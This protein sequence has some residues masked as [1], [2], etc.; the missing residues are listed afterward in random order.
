LAEW[1]SLKTMSDAFDALAK[2]SLEEAIAVADQ[3]FA[4][5]RA[6]AKRSEEDSRFQ[7]KAVAARWCEEHD[8]L[9]ALQCPL[10]TST[11]GADNPLWADL[12]D[13]RA[14]GEAAA[15]TFEDNV[16]RINATLKQ[17]IPI[18]LRAHHADVLALE[19]GKSLAN[20]VRFAFVDKPQ[21]SQALSKFC[22]LVDTALQKAPGT[23]LA[24]VATPE[25]S[26]ERNIAVA[27]R[28]LAL[29]GWFKTNSDSWQKWWN[30]LAEGA[31]PETH[32]TWNT[33]L[34]LATNTLE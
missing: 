17:A 26:V 29:A 10:C 20:S 5:A 15:R 34:P 14:A 27:E 8:L 19:P 24:V 22:T 9:S 1:K 16:S 33:A 23:D 6:L 7:L 21:F 18:S 3:S 4:E 30:E 32:E 13:L 2:S 25:G 12:E 31:A 28:L 11:L